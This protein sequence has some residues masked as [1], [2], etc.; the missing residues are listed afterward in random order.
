MKIVLL[1]LFKLSITICAFS[2][3]ADYESKLALYISG[4]KN[5]AYYDDIRLDLFQKASSMA[6][7]IGIQ[8]DMMNSTN[9]DYRA[10]IST[11]S[12]ILAFRNFMRCFTKS[13]GN[14]CEIEEFNFIMRLLHLVPQEIP[15]LKCDLATFYEFSLED[16]K[17]ILVYNHYPSQE[18]PGRKII[19]VE[20]GEMI[21][22]KV[23]EGS[24]LNVGANKIRCI[25]YNSDK[26]KSYI[27]IVTVKCV[28]YK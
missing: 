13:S 4:F 10:Y 15:N 23:H 6:D 19:T 7:Q 17:A 5:N 22:G 3:I 27:Q 1:L 26:N 2:Q 14:A 21:Y 8:I 11:Q 18:I 28:D 20:Y 16:F 25:G 9:N 12:K 24:F